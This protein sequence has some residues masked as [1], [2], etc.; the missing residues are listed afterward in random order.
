MNAR[1]EGVDRG[2]ALLF[3]LPRRCIVVGGQRQAQALL[4]REGTGSHCAGN[5]VGSR[6]SLDGCG[7]SR[8]YQ[9]S[10][11]KPSSPSLY[12]LQHPVKMQ[13]TVCSISRFLAVCGTFN[14]LNTKRRMVYLKIQF[15]P[16]S[17]H[18]SSRL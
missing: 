8:H 6:A 2:I 14:P 15:V 7:T 18:F 1:E 11:P 16:H 5:W 10:N 13:R 17:K 12:L 4:P 3:L 9:G